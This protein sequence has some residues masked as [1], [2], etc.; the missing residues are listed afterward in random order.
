MK[1]FPGF[2]LGLACVLLLGSAG[3]GGS[4]DDSTPTPSPAPPVPPQP[5]GPSQVAQWLTAPDK[6][7]LFYKSTSPLNF[8][9]T[10]SQNP[11]IIVDTTQSY[12]SIDGFGYTLTGSSAM[13]LK[14]MSA[15]ARAALLKEL[16]AT[17]GASIGTSYLRVS[18]GA[19]DL[20]VGVFTYDDAAQPDPTLAQ[21]SLAPD[22]VNLVPVLKE[23]LAINPS[24]KI[25]GSPWTAPRWMKTN[26]SYIGGAL[27]PEYY[28]AY[29]QYFVK[30]LQA[31]QAEGIRLDAITLQNEPLHDGNNPSMLMSA[32][33][34]ATFIRDHVGPALRAAG[35]TTK[36]ITYDHNLDKPEYPLTI[37]RDPGASQYVD[38]SA[39][40]LYAGDITAM[41]TVRNAFP[42]KNV[43]FTEQW[44]GG[45]GDFAGDLKWHVSNLIIGATRNWSRNVLEWNLAADPNYGPYTPGGCSTCLGA[46]T[47]SGDNVTRNTAYYTVAHAAKFVRPGSVRISTNELGNLPNVAFKNPDGKKVLIVLNA[48]NATQRFAIQYRGNV[49]TTSL[50]KGAVGTYVW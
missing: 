32:L 10:S 5:A 15:T 44:V 11:T 30:Y 48:G 36:I 38:G 28:A 14:Q 21:F 37:L 3:C 49:A 47:I 4:T 12:Q 17:D 34:Q 26:N 25:L 19:S 46:L 45:P 50:D 35:L 41:T 33:E 24:I 18:I 42:S 20:D 31:M 39:F 6:S 13:L 1:L 43:Y 7:A 9:A 29:A 40:H 27:K 23:I 8:Q 22:K 2:R 16:F